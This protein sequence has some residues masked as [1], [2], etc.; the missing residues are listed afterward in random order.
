M[1]DKN[2]D[3]DDSNNVDKLIFGPLLLWSYVYTNFLPTKLWG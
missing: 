1:A 3:M 2:V